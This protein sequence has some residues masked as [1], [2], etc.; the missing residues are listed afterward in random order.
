MTR[1]DGILMKFNRSLFSLFLLVFLLVFLLPLHLK[2]NTPFAKNTTPNIVLLLADDLGYGDVG[3]Y[4]SKSKAP[5][6]HMDKLAGQGRRFTDAHSPASVCSPTRYAILTG[7]YAWRS[8]LKLGVLNPWDEALIEPGRL[9]LPEMLRQHGCTT[10]AF[11]KWHLGW[12]WAT[13]GGKSQM[14]DKNQ[15]YIDLIDFNKPISN[16]PNTRGFD[17]FFGMVGMTPSQPCLIE[18]QNILF[19]GQGDAPPISGVSSETLKNWKDENTPAMLNQKVQ[20]YLKER[21][22]D[23]SKKPFFL[24]FALTTPHQPIFPSAEFRGKTGY[25]EACDFVMQ[26]D[27]SV[28]QVLK[29]LEENHLSENTI[30]IVT[31]DNGSPG[32][33]EADSPTASVMQRYGHDASGGWRGMKGDTHEGGHRVPMIVRWPGKV[34]ANTTSNETVCLVDL[35]ATFGGLVGAKLP[36]N[37]AEDSYDIMPALLGQPLSKPIREATVHHALIGMFAV[38]QGSWKFID[39]LGSGG[40]TMPQYIAVKPGAE[41]RNGITG[42]LF[43]LAD[44]PKESVNLYQKHPEMVEKLSRLLETYKNSGRSTPLRH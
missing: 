31:S 5:T 27:D 25:G 7:R 6:P 33:A 19:R 37:A 16:G 17:Y 32:Y 28:G 10:A 3:C 44:D 30:V 15:D 39:G 2:A 1:P 20:W 36:N 21:A 34:P 43:N 38:R 9:T 8:R 29:S 4:N 14:P 22:A 12:S 35:M 11:G 41:G 13:H 26:T 24:Y 42:Q 18:N 40:F 23:P